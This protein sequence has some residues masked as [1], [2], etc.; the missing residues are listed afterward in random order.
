MEH[1]W[2]FT[3]FLSISLLKYFHAAD[4]GSGIFSEWSSIYISFTNTVH[5]RNFLMLIT[6]ELKQR[7]ETVIHQITQFTVIMTL[8]WG[9]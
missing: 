7:R 4:D 9:T 1:I 3:I 5:K 6:H 2:H 8:V